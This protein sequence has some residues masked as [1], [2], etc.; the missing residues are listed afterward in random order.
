MELAGNRPVTF[1]DMENEAR[2]Q[3]DPRQIREDYRREMQAFVDDLKRRCGQFRI[4]YILAHTDVPWDVQIRE[5]LRRGAG[6][7][8]GRE[9]PSTPL[10]AD[11]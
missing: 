11:C 7:D 10:Q 8:E 1:E 6:S 9:V 3:I 2:L 5:V 4:D